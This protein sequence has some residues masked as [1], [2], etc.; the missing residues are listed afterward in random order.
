MYPPPVTVVV[1]GR[2]LA[3]D[4][5][6]GAGPEVQHRSRH[7]SQIRA[8]WPNL[9]PCA[10]GS[11]PVGRTLLIAARILMHRPSYR[12][13]HT[14]RHREAEFVV[15]PADGAE[16]FLAGRCARLRIPL[17]DQHHPH[18]MSPA[19]PATT[20]RSLNRKVTTRSGVLHFTTRK[21]RWV[22]PA[23]SM[24]LVRSRLT[25]PVPRW[26]NKLTPPPSRTG[27]RSMWI[28]LRGV[29]IDALLHDAR[30][31]HADVLVAGDPL[32]PAPGR[33]RGRR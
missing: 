33:F 21:V 5:R 28:G 15:V 8:L 26:S 12:E 11:P 32:V 27:T 10:S 22:T 29:L 13:G 17:D 31:A 7:S 14:I 16:E 19:G 20:R 1:S 3:V 4:G 6:P 18:V 24:T 25:G 23:P 30:R 9:P 2:V